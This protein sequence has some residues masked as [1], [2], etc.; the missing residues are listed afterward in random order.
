MICQAH[1]LNLLGGWFR[2]LLRVVGWLIVLYYCSVGLT[3]CKNSH[4]AVEFHRSKFD[5]DT[6]GRSQK[7]K[8]S[9][10]GRTREGWWFWQ[11]R[12]SDKPKGK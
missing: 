5:V 9:V 10:R 7:G 2:R 4:K 6:D 11:S 8:S 3:A 1:H 12:P